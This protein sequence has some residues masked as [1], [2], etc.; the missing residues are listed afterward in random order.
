LANSDGLVE[1]RVFDLNILAVFLVK[2]HPGFECV[3]PVV[4]EGLRDIYIPLIMDFFRARY[5][6]FAMITADKPVIIKTT[7]VII[8]NWAGNSG[9]VGDGE[10]VVAV[11][12]TETE[13]LPKFVT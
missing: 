11:L 10:A 13:L 4:E 9:I 6:L 8:S 3:S 7:N 2:G 12:I 1:K 5:P